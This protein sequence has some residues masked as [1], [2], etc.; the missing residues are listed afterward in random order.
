M[1]G[2]QYNNN[3]Q[4]KG[5][6]EVAGVASSV[7]ISSDSPPEVNFK[8]NGNF[9]STEP[10]SV[11][12]TRSPSPSTSTSTL[13]SFNQPTF[14][15]AGGGGG[16]EGKEGLVADLQPGDN[17]G[18]EL[19]RGVAEK[20]N[21]GQEEWEK[22][23][24]ES[25]GQDQVLLRWITGDAEESP[26]ISGFETLATCGSAISPVGNFISSPNPSA[27]GP[28]GSEFSLSENYN[29]GTIVNLFPSLPLSKNFEQQ[30]GTLEQKAQIFNQQVQKSSNLNILSLNPLFYG[31]QQDNHLHFQP[32]PK[33]RNLS[34][35]NLNLGTANANSPVVD[36]GH[37]LLLRS[38]LQFPQMQQPPVGY[39]QQPNFIPPSQLQEK[40]SLVPKQ[41]TTCDNVEKMVA[42]HHVHQ[43]PQQQI[44]YEQVYKAAELILAGNFSNVQGILARLNHVLSPTVKPFQRSAFYFKEALQL[45]LLMSNLNTSPTTRNPTPIDGMFKIGAYKVFSEVSPVIQFMNFT[46]N[47]ALLEA[48]DYA[49]HIHIIDFDIGCG[50]QWS[51]F[52]Q[53]LPRNNR[54]VA[55]LK[56]TA[57]ASP[58]THHPVEISLMHENLTQFA[59]DLGVNFELVV[60]NVDSFDPNSSPLSSLRASESEAIAVNFPIWS[61]ASHLSLLTPFLCFI[62]KLSPKILVSLD[63]GCERTDLPFSHHILNALQYYEALLDSIDAAN[64]PSDA[65]NK[66]EKFLFQPSI[67]STVLGR[68]HF[69]GLTPPWRNLFSSAGFL[70]ASISNF[71][72]TQAEFLVKRTRAKGFLVEKRQASLVLYWQQWELMSVSTWRC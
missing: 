64:T 22:L 70:P 43:Q 7:F 18:M 52:M 37:E 60:V 46:A 42:H 8:K 48:L 69:H 72:E 5:G 17:S 65:A 58:S 39:C 55:S 35:T 31:T 10:I 57:F 45:A 23:L 30:F 32:L 71:A 54:G 56:V 4:A 27:L 63:R 34:A 15:A 51:S 25:A 6:V 3:L 53:Q 26:V 14:A 24:S 66:I 61:F 44:V 1:I 29:D 68:L 59:N 28:F 11:L 2:E 36:L 49:E 33:R 20:Y 19:N 62:K 67:E 40:S 16:G 13:S 41:E 12:D 38:Q 50:A 9:T 47:Q 21:L